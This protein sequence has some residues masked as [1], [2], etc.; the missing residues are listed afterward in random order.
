[1]W[2]PCGN[3]LVLPTLLRL[4]CM[5]LPSAKISAAQQAM[6]KQVAET[7]VVAS[8][9]ANKAKKGI[10]QAEKA[11]PT[12]K[13]N[14][15][16][17]PGKAPQPGEPSPPGWRANARKNGNIPEKEPKKP[18]PNEAKG[19]K[20]SEKALKTQRAANADTATRKEAGLAEF[21]NAAA[22][23]KATIDLPA[24]KGKFN[25]PRGGTFTGKE[26]RIGTFNSHL[27]S[28]SPVGKNAAGKN[29]KTTDRYPKKFDNRFHEVPKQGTV[30]PID[31]M[32]G[33]GHE[34]PIIA[35]K[36]KGYHG[37]HADLGPARVITQP[38][39]NYRTVKSGKGT[40][41]VPE[42][43]F[44]GVIAHDSSRTPGK[45]YN[46]HFQVPFTPPPPHP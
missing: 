36:P 12:A 15:K 1:M 42:T 43:A 22:A 23:Q 3:P 31:S 38:T 34:Y 46:D 26:A 28:A 37:D 8:Q 17:H 29:K 35:G 30:K 10:V 7:K 27:H 24:R 16:G 2:E 6:R 44:K 9:A 33:T 41:T 40:K 21:G 45:G 18:S 39:G 13:P 4:A 32:R 25:E 20:K 14:M 11:D 19:A 5:P